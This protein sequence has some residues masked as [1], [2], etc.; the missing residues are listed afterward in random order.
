MDSEPPCHSQTVRPVCALLNR[1]YALA[2]VHASSLAICLT[3]SRR[4][5]SYVVHSKHCN[6]MNN[7]RLLVI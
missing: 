4:R 5:S 2:I 3:L 7:L 1:V 6:S